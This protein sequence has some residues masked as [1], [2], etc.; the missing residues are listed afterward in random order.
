MPRDRDAAR[1]EEFGRTDPYFGVCSHAA[2]NAGRLDGDAR[3]RFFTSGEEEVARTLATVRTHVAPDFRPRRALDFGCGVARLTIPLA[4]AAELVVG[5]DVSPS[6]L[7]QA[8]DNC[9]RAGVT[10]VDLELSDASLSRAT[11]TFD[12]VHSYIVFQHIAPRA[13]YR[14]L[15]LVLARLALGGIGALHFTYD[16]RASRVR[17]AVHAARRSIPGVNAL[18]NLMQRRPLR[19]PMM[20]MYEYDLDVVRSA[21]RRADCAE[22]HVELTDH[23]GHLG[24]M[25]F[26]RR[27]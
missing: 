5:L 10:N 7:Q 25:L 2:F 22:R 11:G 15:D 20:A 9:A 24:A 27:G 3:A 26:F 16:R 13:G 18:V 14:L 23:D 6:M 12:F 21:L 17:R 4:R 19:S 8:R 1:W